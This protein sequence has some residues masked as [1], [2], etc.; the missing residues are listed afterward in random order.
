MYEKVI[1]LYLICIEF[2]RLYIAIADSIDTIDL[3][4]LVF[5]Y[6]KMLIF[7][8]NFNFLAEFLRISQGSELQ[9]T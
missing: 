2:F 6:I 8:R 7:Y 5:F 9:L 4:I 1:F 3:G